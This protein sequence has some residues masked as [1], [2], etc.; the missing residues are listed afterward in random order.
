MAGIAVLKDNVRLYLAPKGSP[1]MLADKL[2]NISSIG[3]IGGGET[4]EIDV[5]TIDSMAKEFVPGFSDSGSV[6]IVQN[7][8]S[9]EYVTIKTWATANTMLRC[10]VAFKD[11]PQCNTGF[12]CFVKSFS[13]TGMNVGGTL[14]VNLSLRVS[15]AIEDFTEPTT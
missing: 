2:A 3:D 9:D 6:D 12:D 5:T 15:G 8:T 13:L 11:A 7:V 1:L 10:G 14:Q 4:E